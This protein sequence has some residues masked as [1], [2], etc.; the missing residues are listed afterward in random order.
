M[1][2]PLVTRN[3]ND[4]IPASDHN[5]VKAYIEDGSYRVNTNALSIQSTTAIDS[6]GN[7]ILK[8]SSQAQGN[9]LY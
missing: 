7:F 6:S 2:P 8:V 3:T 1:A 5:D 4:L 9:I